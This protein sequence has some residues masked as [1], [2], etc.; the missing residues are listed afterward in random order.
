MYSL[1]VAATTLFSMAIPCR[2]PADH[3]TTTC[4]ID[5]DRRLLDELASPSEALVIDRDTRFAAH[6]RCLDVEL[7]R[8]RHDIE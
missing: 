2:V 7:A 6:R 3:M 8:M 4:R 5:R 1:D